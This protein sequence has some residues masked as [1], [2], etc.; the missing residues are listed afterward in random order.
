[1]KDN[2]SIKQE[3]KDLRNKSFREIEGVLRKYDYNSLTMLSSFVSS[4]CDVETADLLTSSANIY[5][6]QCRALFWY[7]YRY[8]TQDSYE[9]I[10][11]KTA[12]DGCRFSPD[13]VRK[14]CEKMADLINVDP[15][16]KGRWINVKRFIRLKEDPLSY[17]VPD[18][19]SVMPQKYKLMLHVPREIKDQIEIEIKEK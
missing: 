6:S 2:D 5:I 12:I 18:N 7:A 10:S 14:A 16:W 17:Q 4:I 13:T 15:Q 1:M 9:R 3:W 8:M 19:V 11:N